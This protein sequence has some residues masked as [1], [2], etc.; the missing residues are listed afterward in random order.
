M[1]DM[2]TVEILKPGQFVHENKTWLRLLEFFKQE[3]TVLKNRLAEVLDHKNNKEFLALAE[4]FQNLFIIKDEFIDD[5][6]HDVTGQVQALSNKERMT[7]DQKIIKKQEKLR[8]ELEYLEKD[9][10]KLKND[11]NRYL[12]T[13]L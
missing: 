13:H 9:F 6:R 8:N 3:N 2:A 12:S 1:K 4:H 5:L 7:L 11:F 10:S